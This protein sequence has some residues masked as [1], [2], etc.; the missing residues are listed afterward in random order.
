MEQ[1]LPYANDLGLFSEEVDPD[2]GE[3]LGNFPQGLSHLALV[4]AAGAIQDASA[5]RSAGAS[6]KSGAA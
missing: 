4:A 2:S 5:E 6:A 3:L 1:I